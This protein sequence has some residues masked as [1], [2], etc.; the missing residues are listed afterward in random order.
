MSSWDVVVITASNSNQSREY[1][2]R[3]AVKSSLGALSPK[4]E[5]IVIADDYNKRI[6]SGGAVLSVIHK[7]SKKYDF[8]KQKILLINSGGDSKR[9]PQY[10]AS[11]K[12]F[13]NILKY[14]TDGTPAT[15]FDE[16]TKTVD[17]VPDLCQNGM[18]VVSGDIIFN[19][20]KIDKNDF[21]YDAVALSVRV[22]VETGVNHGVFYSED[23]KVKKFLHKCST[24]VLYANN[25]V[26]N[27][28]VNI[29]T[30]AIFLN[31]RIIKTLE[32]LV[33][34]PQKYNLLVNEKTR[35]NF[36][37]DI[38]YPMADFSSLDE[39]A[40][41]KCELDNINSNLLESRKLLWDSLNGYYL[42]LC[43]LKNGSFYHLGTTSQFLRIIKNN[44]LGW[45]KSI[46]CN[47][48]DVYTYNSYISSKAIIKGFVENSYVGENV[49][50]GNN[51]IISG[52]YLVNSIIPDNTVI[53]VVKLVNGKYCLR[54][55]D[56]DCN[57]K[58]NDLW[59][60]EI[61]PVFDDCRMCDAALICFLNRD[62]TYFS[63]EK[64][65]FEESAKYSE[66]NSDL[67]NIIEISRRNYY[68]GIIKKNIDSTPF[69]LNVQYV[70]SKLPLRVNF[71]G[72]WSD[73][74][75]YSN[76]FGGKVLNAAITLNEQLPVS[77]RIEKTDKKALIFRSVDLG[78]EKEYTNIK[79]LFSS[80]NEKDDFLI[81]KAA[82]LACGLLTQDTNLNE[83]FNKYGG[84]RITTNVE[85]IPVGSG[86][87]TSSI[88]CA[89]A[90]DAMY[91]FMSKK[92]NEQKIF[93][94]VLTMEQLMGIGGG[95]QDQIGGYIS[96][97]KISTAQ[98]GCIQKFYVKSLN[99]SDSF[100]GELQKRYLLIYTGQKRKTKNI[101][102]NVMDNIY[103][104]EECFAVMQKI[105]DLA[106]QMTL[107]IEN[108]DIEQ[109]SFLLNEHWLCLKK[110]NKEISNDKIER[111]YKCI[112][113]CLSGFFICG[114]GG[115]GFLQVIL[116]QGY[117]AEDISKK[118]KENS[119]G[120]E[121]MVC[122][123]Y[124]YM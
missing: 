57:P 39:F 40:E 120:D 17:S 76:E 90:A 105:K 101:L 74:S 9:I 95:W 4:T 68:I 107:A 66:Y 86:L 117:T 50:C 19:F 20:D 97:F 100:L 118:L 46:L 87:G 88:L 36:Y 115:G 15:L 89:A 113:N 42:R 65:S 80:Y 51:S 81:H 91:R 72:V 26:E 5:Y 34:D 63:F 8:D 124:F 25:A 3:I 122:R 43:E 47:R 10:A 55:Y 67:N 53:S 92:F 59:H 123:P 35:L 111:I 108:D 23:G 29:D 22:P 16:I 62:K 31:S 52:A 44:D 84:I 56:V 109:F 54:I 98:R 60:A 102:K 7:L 18:L 33:S 2:R 106:D 79:E 71:G 69:E 94:T 70:E 73:A 27:E 75:P 11:G 104:K 37:G 114:A 13:M 1:E 14:N 38:I 28:T 99:V 103:E 93:E 58:Q 116:K 78:V 49:V 48:D 112:K 64:M 119:F 96:G 6:G 121:V 77:C 110:L 45:E 32:K 12:L 21:S 85:N 41:Q 82:C 30:G 61:F 83:F 24:D